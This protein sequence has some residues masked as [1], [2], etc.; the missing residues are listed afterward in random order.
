MKRVLLL[1]VVCIFISIGTYSQVDGV[2]WRANNKSETKK[3][4]NLE[5]RDIKEEITRETFDK[6]LKLINKT[7]VVRGLNNLFGRPAG[8]NRSG[9]LN[10]LRTN[11]IK[12]SDILDAYCNV[13][14]KEKQQIVTEEE[15]EE[16]SE[17]YEVKVEIILPQKALSFLPNPITTLKEDYEIVVPNEYIRYYGY[18]EFGVMES[19]EKTLESHL[20]E[21]FNYI[22]ENIVTISKDIAKISVVT[23]YTMEGKEVKDPSMLRS[24]SLTELGV[25]IAN[26]RMEKAKWE[27]DPLGHIM[28]DILPNKN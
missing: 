14:Y 27:K 22:R 1:L 24:V 12:S 11:E 21:R 5:K 18:N 2:Y 28:N 23:N 9:Y 10:L 17:Y 16:L 4:K 7:E 3:E 20:K 13:E 6:A 15:I 19:Y 8:Y 26:E 25:K